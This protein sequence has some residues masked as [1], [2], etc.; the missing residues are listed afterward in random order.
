MSRER[1]TKNFPTL[2]THFYDELGQHHTQVDCIKVALRITFMLNGIYME[3]Y[4]IFSTGGG[5]A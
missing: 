3:T 5:C 2:G 1:P 4:V